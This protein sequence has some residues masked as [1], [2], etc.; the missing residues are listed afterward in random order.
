MTL[1]ATSLV[2]TGTRA[3]SKAQPGNEKVS[4]NRSKGYAVLPPG[5]AAFSFCNTL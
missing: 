2:V 5:R 1:L 4:A 3:R